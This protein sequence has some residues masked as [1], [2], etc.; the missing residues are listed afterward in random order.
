MTFKFGSNTRLKSYFSDLEKGAWGG[1]L[2]SFFSSVLSCAF[3]FFSIYFVHVLHFSVAKS[4]YILGTYSLGTML[5]GLIGGYFSDKIS[6]KFTAITGLLVESFG[7]I[8]LIFITN[9]YLLML[10]ALMLGIASY[11]FMTGNYTMVLQYCGHNEKNKLKSLSLLTMMAN[12][13][14][15]LSAILIGHISHYGFHYIFT[16][17]GVFLAFLGLFIYFQCPLSSIPVPEK[18]H[19]NMTLKNQKM[20]FT[21][22]LFCVFFGGA[23]VM[24]YS[25][26]YPVY[27]KDT[28]P[29][30]GIS[31]MSYLFALNCILVVVLQPPVSHLIQKQNKLLM[32]GLGSFLQGLSLFMLILWHNYAYA[33]LAIFISTVGEV[34]FFPSVQLLCH[35]ASKKNKKGKG[36]G[37]YRSVYGASRAFGASAGG[38][39]YTMWSPVNLWCVN[40]F[41]GL[42]CLLVCWC[43]NKIYKKMGQMVI[44]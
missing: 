25:S 40:G 20:I 31:G 12:L 33:M 35:N 22:V 11:M 16:F 13:G 9:P 38:F 39:I 27:I 7:Y 36:I 4:G 2:T 30:Y 19:E 28:F 10:N 18:P 29:Q 43:G 26:T 42:L 34:I 44:E 23:I 24:Q 1:I 15:S 41:V 32:V 37:L 17:S 5:G 8:L 3:Y 21:I 14:L 6:P